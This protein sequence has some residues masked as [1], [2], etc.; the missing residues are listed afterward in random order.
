MFKVKVNNKRTRNLLV[1]ALMA[2]LLVSGGALMLGVVKPLTTNILNPGVEGAKSGMW[3]TMITTASQGEQPQHGIGVVHYVG[4]IPSNRTL[5]QVGNDAGVQTSQEDW[6]WGPA[7]GA[8]DMTIQHILYNHYLISGI[9][10]TENQISTE[11]E[12][13][14]Q[15]QDF[16]YQN[17]TQNQPASLNGTSNP[18]Q[19]EYLQYWHISN[20]T[21]PNGSITYNVT[22]QDIL[23]VPGDFHIDVWIVPSQ[24]NPNTDSGWEEGSF[25]NIEFWYTIYWYD[26]MNSLG[27]VISTDPN[28]PTIPANATITRDGLFSL[29]GGVPITAWIQNYY[30]PTQNSNGGTSFNLLSVFERGAT[31]QNNVSGSS[32]PS[33]VYSDLLAMVDNGMVPSLGGRYLPLYTQPS[34][35]FS[36]VDLTSSNL[37]NTAIDAIPDAETEIPQEY[38]KIGVTGLGT[39]V[40]GN[41]LGYTVYYPVVSY[42]IRVIMAVYGTHTYIWT[43]SAAQHFGYP[44]WQ[45]RTLEITYGGGIPGAADFLSWLANLLSNPLIQ[46]LLLLICVIVIIGLLAILAPGVLKLFSAAGSAGAQKIKSASKPKA[47]RFFE[48]SLFFQ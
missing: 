9:V 13:N 20:V 27:Q 12:T 47:R 7:S 3:G 16:N 44:G 5:A 35:N 18:T 43:T 46:L 33:S 30:M 34:D 22:K 38:F 8:S 1:L 10:E 4:A 15:L 28:P 2:I 39:D 29:R 24:S 6:Y 17:I 32:L 21:N 36:Y 37:E 19:A 25:S 26:W 23:L 11:T 42:L 45:N 14:I 48:P 40:R 31:T 41:V